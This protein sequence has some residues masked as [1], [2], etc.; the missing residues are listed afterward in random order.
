M[1]CQLYKNSVQYMR[2]QFDALKFNHGLNY[3]FY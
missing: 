1:T 3:K 2:I